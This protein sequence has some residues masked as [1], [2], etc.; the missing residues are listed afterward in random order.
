[1]EKSNKSSIENV[2]DQD[3]IVYSNSKKPTSKKSSTPKKPIP[4]KPNKPKPNKPKPTEVAKEIEP[5]KV[6]EPNHEIVEQHPEI[7]N[8]LANPHKAFTGHYCHKCLEKIYEDN[9]KVKK[10]ENNT[11]AY[12][13]KKCPKMKKGWW[14]EVLKALFLLAV[15]GAI[16][17]FG[18]G[19][20]EM[21]MGW[22]E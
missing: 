16:I 13:H 1:M 8:P 4:K 14:K 11:V 12:S 3:E 22:F 5:E 10:G 20:V 2:N 19:L 18:K 17:Y 7:D 15:L 9:L 6:V 21:A